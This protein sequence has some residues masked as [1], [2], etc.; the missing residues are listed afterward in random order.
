MFVDEDTCQLSKL[1]AGGEL[2]W[3]G[4]NTQSGVRLRHAADIDFYKGLSYQGMVGIL[5]PI[6]R[7]F[8]RLFME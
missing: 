2:G 1:M 5:D 6:H 7:S 3:D 8:S 4:Y